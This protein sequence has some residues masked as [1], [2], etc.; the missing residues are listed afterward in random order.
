MLAGGAKDFDPDLMDQVLCAENVILTIRFWVINSYA[1]RRSFG[2]ARVT[3]DGCTVQVVNT[4]DDS[5]TTCS[6]CG[7]VQP[8]PPSEKTFECN[9]CHY[10]VSRQFNSAQYVRYLGESGFKELNVDLTPS[11]NTVDTSN[12]PL[13]FTDG[14]KPVKI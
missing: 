4:L 10:K 11:G 3:R 6:Q 2:Q 1:R 5:S 14:R 7:N 13:S 12:R 8:C 9:K